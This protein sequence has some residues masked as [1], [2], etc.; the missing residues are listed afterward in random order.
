MSSRLIFCKLGRFGELVK[1]FD[2]PMSNPI[3]LPLA[4][5]NG[6]NKKNSGITVSG[7][8]NCF[9]MTQ[10]FQTFLGLSFF[11]FERVIFFNHHI[12]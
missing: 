11:F 1:V 5:N 10:M 7:D 3:N 8:E 2:K 12:L 9:Q 4:T 6:D